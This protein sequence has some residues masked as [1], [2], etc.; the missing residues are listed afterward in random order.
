MEL[1]IKFE[2]FIKRLYDLLH[3]YGG[4][5]TSVKRLPGVI[6]LIHRVDLAGNVVAFIKVPEAATVI[7]RL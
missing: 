1:K 3:V 5:M 2:L 6:F 4:F 7:R